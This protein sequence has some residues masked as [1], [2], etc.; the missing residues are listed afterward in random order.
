M[1]DDFYRIG[2]LPPYVFAEVNK[3]KASARANGH[4]II[5][6]GM[7][8]PDS[9]PPKH[10]MDKLT[11]TMKDP[12][13]SRY[14]LSRGIHGLRKAQ[15]AYY[16]KRFGVELDPDS[17]IVVTIGSK[18][19]LA[20]LAQ[21]LC[22]ARSVLSHPYVGFCDCR[23]QCVDHSQPT[24]QPGFF[25]ELEKM[26]RGR[27]EKTSGDGGE[28]S[29]QP[30]SGIGRSQFLRAGDRHREALRHLCDFRPGLQRVVFR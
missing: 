21:L 6:F 8:N 15:A 24:K 1:Q 19:G 12:K 4:D 22:R 2:R 16:Q 7:G 10:V 27:A 25:P 13:S 3:M 23:W 29:V 20:N 14:S 28:L 9:L 26:H 18:E 5:D 30:D 11:E 17:E